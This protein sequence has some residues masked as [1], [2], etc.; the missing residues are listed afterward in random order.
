MLLRKMLCCAAAVKDLPMKGARLLSKTT[1][2]LFLMDAPLHPLTIHTV[3]RHQ[4]AHE[5]EQDTT[6]ESSALSTVYLPQ[7]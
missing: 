1:K 3:T 4:R 2:V 5:Q 6:E 7:C